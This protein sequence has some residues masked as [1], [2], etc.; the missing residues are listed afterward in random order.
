MDDHASERIAE[1]KLPAPM[2]VVLEPIGPKIS[3]LTFDEDGITEVPMALAFR[4]TVLTYSEEDQSRFEWMKQNSEGRP[5]IVA[6]C[7][8]HCGFVAWYNE[9]EECGTGE[10]FTVIPPSEAGKLVAGHQVVAG[11]STQD[12][13]F[14]EKLVE[15]GQSILSG[16]IADMTRDQYG[17]WSDLVNNISAVEMNMADSS[18]IVT[19]D[20]NK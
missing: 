13:L 19:T 3:A 7:T 18:D 5:I 4:A 15:H 14:V 17:D 9:H 12:A 11:C 6:I 2:Y 1:F 10:G 16:D 20:D 8:E